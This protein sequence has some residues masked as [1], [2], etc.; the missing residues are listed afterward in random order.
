M[1]MAADPRLDREAERQS[2]IF[3]FESLGKTL[4]EDAFRRYD[5]NKKRFMGPFLI[6]AFEA[7]GLGLGY[8]HPS[9]LLANQPPSVEE[10]VAKLWSTKEFLEHIGSGISASS[11]LSRTIRIGREIFKP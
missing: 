7:I 2:F 11:R 6:S 9:W 1:E 3:A 10:V 5:A 4:G 8:N